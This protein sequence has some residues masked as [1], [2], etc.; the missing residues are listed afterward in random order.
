MGRL[1][2]GELGEDGPVDA[3][4]QPGRGEAGAVVLRFEVLQRQ[5]EVEDVG[6]AGRHALAERLRAGDGQHGRD[7]RGRAELA[8]GAGKQSAARQARLD[9]GLDRIEQ[10]FRAGRG[11]KCLLDHGR[12]LKRAGLR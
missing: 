6:E 10:R 2:L 1:V 11:G 4:N 3:R 9:L 5:S 8:G 7:R 12:H